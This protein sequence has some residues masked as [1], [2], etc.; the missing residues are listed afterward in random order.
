MISSTF[1]KNLLLLSLVSVIGAC[2]Q[3]VP[4]FDD[5]QKPSQSDITQDWLSVWGSGSDNIW[6]AGKKSEISRFKVDHWEVIENPSKDPQSTIRSIYGT[7]NTVIFAGEVSE[8]GGRGELYN[9]L[10][11]GSWDIPLS[12]NINNE[13]NLNEPVSIGMHSIWSHD[14]STWI[15]G[16]CG[17]AMCIVDVP[18]GNS[19]KLTL[20]RKPWFSVDNTCGGNSSEEFSFMYGIWGIDNDNIWAV[21][22]HRLSKSLR[23][24]IFHWE[25]GAWSSVNSITQPLRAVWG[26]SKN[27]VWAV[28]DEGVIIHWNGSVWDAVKYENRRLNSI[29]GYDDVN[30]WA[31][32][33]GGIILHFD[34]SSWKQQ[35][36]PTENNL[37]GV[38]GSGPHDVWIVGDKGT[39]LMRVP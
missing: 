10:F 8:Y 1:Y 14:L 3:R 9:R 16:R 11:E 39:V 24:E 26:S 28:G 25:N 4:L 32:G 7:N 29:W 37:H 34:G 2:W 22:T 35:P 30:I 23:G 5:K 13:Y 19:G 36:S 21:G 31:V 20:S 15:A 33:D 12:L 27:D 38:Y 18:N 17:C 6:I